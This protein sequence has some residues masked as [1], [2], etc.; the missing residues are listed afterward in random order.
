[1]RESVASEE[2]IVDVRVIRQ[3]LWRVSWTLTSVSLIDRTLLKKKDL[4]SSFLCIYIV[5]VRKVM[6]CWAPG[7]C[8]CVCLC[9]DSACVSVTGRVCFYKRLL[10]FSDTCS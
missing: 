7:S 8:A 4:T 5:K 10:W 3:D 2:A 9:Y 6:W 1:M